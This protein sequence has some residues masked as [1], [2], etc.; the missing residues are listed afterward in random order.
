MTF[1]TPTPTHSFHLLL[2]SA[3]GAK[4]RLG[5]RQGGPHLPRG[6]SGG[7]PAA[8]RGVAGRVAQL[9]FS[10]AVRVRDTRLA[11]HPAGPHQAHAI[12]G[13]SLD[14]RALTCLAWA[15]PRVSP[16]EGGL[17]QASGRQR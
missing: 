14:A 7:L 17:A 8:G 11:G 9:N 1:C 4:L 13:V 16:A 2:S 6:G 15:V 5:W 12:S 3:A 10:P